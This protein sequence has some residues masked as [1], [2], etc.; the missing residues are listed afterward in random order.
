MKFRYKVG[1]G[2]LIVLTALRLSYD[3]PA[4]HWSDVQGTDWGENKPKSNREIETENKIK[5]GF[6][7]HNNSGNTHSS[8]RYNSF[9]VIN[10]YQYPG[11]YEQYE[12]KW[13]KPLT[14]PEID[15][16]DPYIQDLIEDET[17]K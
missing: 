11:G 5:D 6:T 14:T 2:V 10:K 3:D 1:I 13:K 15:Y 8:D 7:P 12:I 16:S 4:D 9:E 17:Q